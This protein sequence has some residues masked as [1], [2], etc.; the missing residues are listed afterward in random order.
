MDTGQRR[1]LPRCTREL[2]HYDGDEAPHPRLDYV[3][4]VGTIKGSD[5]RQNISHWTRL[6][7]WV[8][9]EMFKLWREGD[10]VALATIH[11][12]F[13][14]L[15]VSETVFLSPSG[16]RGLFAVRIHS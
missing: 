5:S 2:G 9:D 1:Y 3:G 10:F 8:P 14:G 12:G 6:I 11:S 13:G 7:K 16:S 4:P 15:R